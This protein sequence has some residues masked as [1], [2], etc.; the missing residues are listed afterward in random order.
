VP[1]FKLT[2]NKII[3]FKNNHLKTSQLPT[4]SID[5]NYVIS[6]T[7]VLPLFA[8]YI[9]YISKRVRKR[10]FLELSRTYG[11]AHKA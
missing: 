3:L 5:N 11:I 2:K 6:L 10:Q 1:I 7:C 9:A 4:Q 8:A